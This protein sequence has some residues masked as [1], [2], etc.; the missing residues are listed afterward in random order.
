[1]AKI[2]AIAQEI[3]N[4]NRPKEQKAEDVAELKKYNETL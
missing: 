3:E 2:S 1:M 4:G